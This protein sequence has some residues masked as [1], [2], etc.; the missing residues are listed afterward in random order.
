MKKIKIDNYTFLLLILLFSCNNKKHTQETVAVNENTQI[1]D[2]SKAQHA[3]KIFISE[4]CSRVK[5][6][7]LENNENALLGK[8]NGMQVYKD[9]I[10]ILDRQQNAGVYLF[11][12]E[13]KF[14]R[15]YGRRGIGPGEYLQISD[16]T[17][18]T[19]NDAIYL[20]DCDANQILKYKIL[21]GEY[22]SS[23]KLESN[24]IQSFHIQYNNKELYTDINYISEVEAGC[25][26]R[27]IDPSTGK[28]KKC[29]LDN[30][31]YNNGWNGPIQR[32][33]ESFFYSRIQ[34]TFKYVH[35]FM[36]TIISFQDN[37]I[38]PVYVLKDNEWITKNEVQQLKEERLANQGVFSFQQLFDKNV[39]FNI[40]SYVEWRDY[41]LFCYQKNYNSFFVL[42]NIQTSDTRVSPLFIDDLACNKP[43][44]INQFS[45][46]DSSGLY[47]IMNVND[48]NRHI[49][50]SGKEDFLNPNLDKIDILKN[51]PEDSNPVIFYYE[52]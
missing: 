33:N 2:V 12:K 9:W 17:I 24:N 1:I 48:L 35:F 7:I 18:D 34:G 42:H 41:I 40:N 8:I 50:Q 5:T 43:F 45:C 28:Q 13:G 47:S 51:L 26:I 32:E 3:D 10:F 52:F 37:R 46:S 11:S 14:I 19:D 27:K 25:M 20:M 44:L 29:W 30:N 39:G 36:N 16:F 4:L 38:V 22:E 15:K 23:V 6:I 21:S 31:I 49:E